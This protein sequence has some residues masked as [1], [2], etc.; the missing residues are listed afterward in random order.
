M[1]SYMFQWGEKSRKRAGGDQFSIDTCDAEDESVGS[2]GVC[3]MPPSAKRKMEFQHIQRERE[4]T[5][6]VSIESMARVMT[7]I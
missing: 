2:I 7:D 4:T 1:S 6:F 5:F 3:Q